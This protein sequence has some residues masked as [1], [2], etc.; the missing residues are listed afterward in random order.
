M[1]IRE[2]FVHVTFYY[3]R[4]TPGDNPDR[5]R[6]YHAAFVADAGRVQRALAGWLAMPAPDLPEIPVWNGDPPHRVQALAP[7]NSLEGRTN[8]GAMIGTYALRNMLLLRVIVA[9]AGDHPQA[10]WTMLDEALGAPPTT[11]S[12]LHTTH[13]WCGIAPRPPEDL[14]QERSL[15]IKTPFGV[16]CMAQAA[17]P[18]LLVYPDARTESRASGFLRSLAAELDWFTVQARHRLEQYDDHAAKATRNQQRQQ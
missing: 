8:A 16:L 1:I 3:L 2:P 6:E 13:Y 7:G 14:E 11:P 15:P 5:R 9:R 12:W 18:H 10:V 4:E 17:E